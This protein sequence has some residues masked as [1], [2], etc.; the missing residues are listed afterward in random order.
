M[1]RICLVLLLAA[2]SLCFG[3]YDFLPTNLDYD[4]SITS[5]EKFF[6][7]KI[8]DRHLQHYQIVAYCKYLA[9]ESDRVQ[10][11][12]YGETH[13][14]RSLG[15][16]LISSP[17]NLANRDQIQKQ[18]L[19]LQDPEESSRLNLKKM[20]IVINLNYSVHGNE[21]SGANAS[22]L[23]AYYLAAAQ[24]AE[25]EE[26]LNSSIILLDPVLNP[27]G[28]DR[29]ANWTNSN[30]GKNPNPDP[31][32]REHKEGWPNGRT[33]YYLFDLNRDWMLLTQP[34]SRGRIKQYH[35]W[36][37]NFVLDFHEMGTDATY[38]FQLG[39]PSRSHPLIPKNVYELT[40]RVSLYF[41]E[42]LD[43]KNSL[44]FTQEKFDDF[45]MGKGSTISDLKGAIGILFEQ[46]SARGIIQDGDNGPVSFK[47]AISNQ[48]A[49]SLSVLKGASEMRLQFL[50]HT[51]QFYID[52]LKEAGKQPFSG[53]RFSSGSDPARANG[54]VDV[55]RHHD[56]EVLQ[57]ADEDAW[58]IPLEQP[59]YKYLEALVE[60]R[61]EFEESIFYDITAWTLP[62]AYN[63]EWE[64]LKKA[65]KLKEHSQKSVVLEQSQKGYVFDWSDLNA[66]KVLLNLQQ[67]GVRVKIAK[68]PFVLDKHEFGY[69][70]VFIPLMQQPEKADIVYSIMQKAAN[71]EEVSVASVSSFLTGKGIDLGSDSFATIEKPK[72]LLAA[73][74]GVDTYTT[75]SVW[76]LLDAVY[77]F[78]VT[79]VEP[80]QLERIN[81]DDYTALI[82]PGAEKGVYPPSLVQ[83]LR[84]WVKQGGSLICLGS[85]SKWAIEN[86]LVSLSLIEVEEKVPAPVRPF[87][88]ARDDKALQDIKGAI[89]NT[90]I[91][92]SHPLTYGY[93]QDTLPVFLN[94]TDFL[95]RTESPYQTPLVYTENPLLAGYAS[96]ENLKRLPGAAAVAVETQGQGA[97][98]LFGH[99][100]TFRAYWKGTE[101]LL[102]NAILFGQLMNPEN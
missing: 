84:D 4:D 95:S 101:K 58:Y 96:D 40:Q 98:I 22:Q 68:Q 93:K 5:P 66:P 47:F 61:K 69:G 45:Y 28:L 6:A 72:I 92:I 70:S 33:N 20:P 9:E 39:V 74:S 41:A 91:D 11:V 94:R 86:E 54:F 55:L 102:L 19:L 29:F 26:L 67:A 30:V 73:T 64:K 83:K 1:K 49:V 3:T 71:L 31:N 44:Y 46:A 50:Q 62:L 63:L 27:D 16:L 23:I 8:G 24:S 59:Q 97:I 77:D 12:E 87:V 52:S 100:P 65:P 48:V 25:I 43:K 10:W 42:A 78:P 36:L 57:I 80:R 79:I 90:Q 15:Q 2:N 18:H 34:E 88:K 60:Q 35:R 82:L 14:N 53:Y 17:E 21:A 37:P 99:H 51:K 32:T 81:I 13:G 38:F 76:H 75:G 89:F 7:F 85:T 56:I